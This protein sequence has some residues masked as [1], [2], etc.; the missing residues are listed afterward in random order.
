MACLKHQFF[1][2][3]HSEIVGGFFQLDTTGAAVVSL[4]GVVHLRLHR[5][6]GGV[7]NVLFNYSSEERR[8]VRLL[9]E[10]V[11]L[12]RNHVKLD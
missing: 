3:L 4:R 11:N 6:R 2:V 7:P 10:R 9:Q 5:L 1:I 12:V 8:V